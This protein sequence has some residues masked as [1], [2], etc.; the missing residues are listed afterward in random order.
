MAQ[1][2]GHSYKAKEESFVGKRIDAVGGYPWN[3]VK[4]E[5]LKIFI[6]NPGLTKA[7]IL[8]ANLYYTSNTAPTAKR[9]NALEIS[10]P[11]DVMYIMIEK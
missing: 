6:N 10:V 2:E 3:V 11:E 9:G 7:T 8:D 4:T 1:S 5:G